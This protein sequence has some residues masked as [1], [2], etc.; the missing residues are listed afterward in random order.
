MMQ[1][2]WMHFP[3]CPW[4]W[5]QGVAPAIALHIA[6]T[7]RGNPAFVIITLAVA[8]AI[9]IAIGISVIVANSVTIAVAVA[10]CHHRRP[11]PL[12]SP[13]TITTAV[14][15]VLPSAI[16]IAVAIALAIGHCHLHHR[17]PLQ[18]PSPLAITVTVAIGHFREFLPWHG[19]NCIQP[20]EAIMLT[21]FYFV[22]TVGGTLIKAG[23][24]T[25]CQAA[26]TNTSVGQQAASSE[27]LVREVAGS[28]GAAGGQQGGDVDWP[29]EVL[30]CCVVGVSAVD[31]WH[32]WWCVGYGRRHCQWD[33]DWTDAR[34]KRD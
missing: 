27:R 21:L 19:K 23:W 12:R 32:L 3:L 11:L 17:W 5:R 33:S 24:L 9:V 28:R 7:W 15:V 20:I 4:G 13:S 16:A 30:F 34:R 6:G 18:L 26:I 8:V 29:W 31:R 10:H 1:R 22:W 25:R 14:F 2:W